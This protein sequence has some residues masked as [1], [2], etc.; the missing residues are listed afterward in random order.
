L[1][2][3]RGLSTREPIVS[4]GAPHYHFMVTVLQTGDAKIDQGVGEVLSRQDGV[5]AVSSHF[6]DYGTV[7]YSVEVSR[8]YSNGVGL[9]QKRSAEALEAYFSVKGVPISVRMGS[10]GSGLHPTS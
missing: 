1:K 10:I 8:E 3:V 9:I 5:S 4:F 7:V 2:E 6:V